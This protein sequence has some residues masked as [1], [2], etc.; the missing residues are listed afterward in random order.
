MNGAAFK[1]LLGSHAKNLQDQATNH[2]ATI[3]I[4]TKNASQHVT[5]MTDS[6]NAML[7]TAVERLTEQAESA[8]DASERQQ[9]AMQDFMLKC[10]DR[11]QPPDDRSHGRR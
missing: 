9:T 6:F 3:Q 2:Q 1:S 5:T 10:L 4:L 8:R 7:S 11:L